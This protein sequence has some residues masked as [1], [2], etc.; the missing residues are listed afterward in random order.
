LSLSLE[1]PIDLTPP[2]PRLLIVSAPSGAGKTTLCERVIKEHSRVALSVS[3][4][5]RPIRPYEKEGVHYH[6]VERAVFEQK[7]ERGD[8]AEW[9][10]VHGKLYGSDRG[11]IDRTLSEGKHLLFDI[12]V[13]GALN[14][15]KL[16]GKRTLLIFIEPPSFEILAGRL[17]ARKSDSP[18]VIETR[19]RNAYDELQ[20]SR[21]FDYQIVNDDLENAYQELRRII[22]KECL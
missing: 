9:A 4:T 12:D 20:W 2:Q 10:E 13:Q 17:R 7:V 16:Y 18:E 22:E 19:L 8:F 3:T 6:F 1:K 5:T 14:L 15:R 21:N 11:V